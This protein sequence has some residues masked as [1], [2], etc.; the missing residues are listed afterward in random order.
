[1]YVAQI[2]IGIFKR[3]HVSTQNE[4]IR[5]LLECWRSSGQILGREFILVKEDE[6]WETTVGIP[7]RN[8]FYFK[9]NSEYAQRVISEE[10]PRAGLAPVSTQIIGADPPG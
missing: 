5:W 1:M 3:K 7:A 4:T 9:H 6:L 10:F 8:A 2:S